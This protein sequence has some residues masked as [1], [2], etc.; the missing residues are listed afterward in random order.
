[1]V[2][3]WKAA[4]QLMADYFSSRGQRWPAFDATDLLSRV[5]HVNGHWVNDSHVSEAEA[6]IRR[7][8]F[9]V[10]DL[11]ENY[12]RIELIFEDLSYLDG[13]I[14]APVYGYAHPDTRR[15]A[16]CDRARAY[17]P[18]C[19]TTIIHEVAH[20][21][22]HT[23]AKERTIVYCPEFPGRSPEEVEANQ[24]MHVAL[25]PKS[26]L[27]LAIAWLCHIQGIDLRLAV[28]SANFK[29]GRWIW[30]RRLFGPLI[31]KLCVS[32]ELVSLKM[33]RTLGVFD[34]DT[35]NFHKTYHLPTKWRPKNLTPPLQR[36]IRELM[37]ELRLEVESDVPGE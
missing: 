11:V 31:G 7:A 17:E 30:R 35:V 34:Q 29:R 5:E 13:L 14:G 6:V 24:F 4:A 26:V 15:I 22:L 27:R 16:V 8:C 20:I 33:M 1:M 2:K 25:L 9:D 10:D 32:R 23:A 21:L 19:R 36:R 3:P 28:G 18:L 37:R 12:L